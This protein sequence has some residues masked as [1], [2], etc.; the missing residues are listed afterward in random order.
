MT[1]TTTATASVLAFSCVG[2]SGS[3]AP[4]DVDADVLV[5]APDAGRRPVGNGSE[6]AG[7]RPPEYDDDGWLRI[8]VDPSYGCPSYTATRPDQ[9]PPGIVWEPCSAPILALYPSC[10]TMK[11]DGPFNGRLNG[12]VVGGTAGRVDASGKTVLAFTRRSA[13]VTHHLVGEADGA[14]RLG[15]H[16]GAGSCWT[17]TPRLAEGRAL[18]P[19]ET[20]NDDRSSTSRRGAI[21]GA[22]DEAAVVLESL[23][24][25]Y[26]SYSAGPDMFLDGSAFRAWGP[27][28]PVLSSLGEN[29]YYA[30]PGIFVG[31]AFFF[32]T[33]DS[34]EHHRVRIYQA[35]SG[36]RDFLWYGDGIASAAADFGTDGKDM[37]W[38]EAFGRAYVGDDWSAVHLVTAPY[39]TDP[40]KL[41]KRELR[42]MERLEQEPYVVGCGHA[43]GRLGP[44]ITRLR[45]GRFATLEQLRS[46]DGGFVAGFTKALAITCDEVFVT[47]HGMGCSDNV[48]RIRLDDLG[49]GS[50]P[51]GG[52]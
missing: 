18:Y 7:P 50:Q 44:T 2:G 26:R 35:G 32:R 37:V 11:T 30:D 12:F 22:F 34:F 20:R 24:A 25:D 48:V 3:D 41:E 1:T 23:V 51:D 43:V 29:A 13:N 28:A 17:G 21:G 42:S 19:V 45:D 6:D 16:D 46:D 38:T 4:P 39:T 52:Q 36:V 40:S 49:L 5:P 31:D 10:R 14:I 33:N 47:V 15:L 9:M 27:N 8:D